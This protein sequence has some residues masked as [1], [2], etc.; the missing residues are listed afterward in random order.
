MVDRDALAE[1][2]AQAGFV[3][4]DEDADDLIAAAGDDDDRLEALVGRR[5]T[6]EPI[7]WIT[8]HTY[9]AGLRVRVDPAVYVPR[10]QTEPLAERAAERLPADGV[11]ID[12]CT[13]CGAVAMVM[14]AARPAAR[15]VGVDID[16]RAVANA[17]ANGVEAYASDLFTAVPDELRGGVDVVVGVVPY[18][19]TPALGLLQ[20]DTFTFETPLA[21][22]GGADGAG[23]LRRVVRECRRFLKPGGALLLELGGDQADMLGDDLA[24]RGFHDIE[25]LVDQ[26]DDVRG[27]EARA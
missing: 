27:I 13:G 20:R 18:V 22:D 8:G 14:A 5:L 25:V 24:R 21:Y 1:R 26:E 16:E 19:P 17:R 9:F 10:W 6:G 7:A 4:A 3:A 2:L 12:V 15:V 23:I 11:A